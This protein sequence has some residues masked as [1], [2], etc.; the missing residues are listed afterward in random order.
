MYEMEGPHGLTSR[1]RRSLGCLACEPA[2][3]PESLAASSVLPSSSASW[4][5]ARFAE[6]SGFPVLPSSRSCLRVGP[7]F[8]WRRQFLVGRRRVH[9]GFP[10]IIFGG[11]RHPQ[12]VHRMAALL[13][14]PSPVVHRVIHGSVHSRVRRRPHAGRRRR[15]I[16][17]AAEA[18][19]PRGRTATGRSRR[20][21]PDRC[22]RCAPGRPAWPPPGRRAPAPGRCGGRSRTCPGR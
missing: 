15:L 3:G 9:K 19:R 4:A 20:G 17:V 1:P 18:P 6:F 16:R 13:P 7:R 21:W 8:R 22:R 2:R 14:R 10:A 11:F 12:D 5:C